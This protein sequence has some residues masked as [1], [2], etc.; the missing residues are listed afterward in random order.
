MEAIHYDDAP[1]PVR[2]DITA[3]HRRSWERL[4]KAGTWWSGAERVAIATEVRDAI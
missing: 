1:Y 2:S 3:S 4:A